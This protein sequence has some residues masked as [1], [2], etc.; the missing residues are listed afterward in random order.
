MQPYI[1]TGVFTKSL[2]GINTQCQYLCQIR[3]EEAYNLM[4]GRPPSTPMMD[5]SSTCLCISVFAKHHWY[6]WN[7]LTTSN[8]W[9]IIYLNSGLFWSHACFLF[10]F[11]VTPETCWCS[12]PNWE[13][14]TCIL[15]LRSVSTSLN[16]PVWIL[17]GMWFLIDVYLWILRNNLQCSTDPVL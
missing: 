10:R 3:S 14:I 2:S 17:L 9:Y 5:I 12:P 16:V 4:S 7:F 6:S 11:K 13:R 8:I 1:E 15:S